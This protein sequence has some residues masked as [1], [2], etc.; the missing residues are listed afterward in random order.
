MNLLTGKINGIGYSLKANAL[1]LAKQELEGS[2]EV[3]EAVVE[4]FTRL[5]DYEDCGLVPEEIIE[6]EYRIQSLEK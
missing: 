3:L 2:K 1:P 6:M 4:I 5:A